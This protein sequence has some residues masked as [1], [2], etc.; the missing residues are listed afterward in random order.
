MIRR[1]CSTGGCKLSRLCRLSHPDPTQGNRSAMS[2]HLDATDINNNIFM[3]TIIAVL[4]LFGFVLGALATLFLMHWWARVTALY[5]KK[6]T[7]KDRDDDDSDDS[8]YS[9]NLTKVFVS[10]GGHRVHKMKDCRGL[11]AADKDDIRLMRPCRI[12][13]KKQQ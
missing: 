9:V 4:V 5:T 10:G 3:I 11:G 2:S 12:C 1:V 8:A 7:K 6:T 13:F